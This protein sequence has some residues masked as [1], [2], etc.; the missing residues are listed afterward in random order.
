MINRQTGTVAQIGGVRQGTTF[1]VEAVVPPM[2]SD[3]EIETL[4]A[5]SSVSLPPPAIVPEEPDGP[6]PALADRGRVLR[7]HRRPARGVPA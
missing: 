7:W 2:L 1:Q 4:K 6:G 3:E 5:D